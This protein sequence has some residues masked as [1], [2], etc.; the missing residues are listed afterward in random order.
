MRLPAG[1]VLRLSGHRGNSGVVVR[2]SCLYSR[3]AAVWIWQEK[4]RLLPVVP[5]A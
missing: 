5:A 1:D 2:Q 3:K 4:L